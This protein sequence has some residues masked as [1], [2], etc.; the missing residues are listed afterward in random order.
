VTAA[1]AISSSSSSSSSSGQQVEWLQTAEATLLEQLPEHSP[2][3]ASI[4]LWALG[5]LGYRPRQ[6]LTSELECS[7]ILQQQR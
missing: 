2:H 4:C 5:K 1:A 7:V 6:E 3:S